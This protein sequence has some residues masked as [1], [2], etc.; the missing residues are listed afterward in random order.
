MSR[1]AAVVVV[2]VDFNITE[3][4]IRKNNNIKA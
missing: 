4:F 2:V 1:A 3:L